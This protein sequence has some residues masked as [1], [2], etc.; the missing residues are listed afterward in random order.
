[1]TNQANELCV[2]IDLGTT[3]SVIAFTNTRPNGDLVS[4]V[5]SARRSN[6]VY[7]VAGSG[8]SVSTVLEPT[9]PSVVY[10]YHQK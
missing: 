2:G 9:L 6:D 10:Y 5:F 4:R 7:Y 8:Q 1:M 3:N